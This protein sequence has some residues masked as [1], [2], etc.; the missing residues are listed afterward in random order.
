MGRISLALLRSGDLNVSECEIVGES[1]DALLA[2]HGGDAKET[3]E[4]VEGEPKSAGDLCQ[5]SAVCKLLLGLCP[6]SPVQPA[7]DAHTD[8]WRG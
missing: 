6:V 1:P 7:W 8:G 2:S 3:T 4:G 5:G